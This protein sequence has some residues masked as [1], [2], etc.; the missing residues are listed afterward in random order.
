MPIARSPGGMRVEVQPRI[1]PLRRVLVVDDD[2]RSR[3]AVARLLEEEGYAAAVASD[4]EEAASMLAALRPDL[5]LTDLTMPRLDGLGL[6]AHVR[7]MLPDTPVIILS[8]RAGPDVV[9]G[10]EAQGFLSKPV[11]VEELLA[12]IRALIGP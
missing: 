9:A 11:H 6:L 8:A 10:A 1:A 12:R 2:A 5:V 3:S 4:G 7:R